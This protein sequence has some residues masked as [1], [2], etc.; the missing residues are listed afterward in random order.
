MNRRLFLLNGIAIVA[1]VC[2]HATHLGY[3]ALFANPNQPNLVGASWSLLITYYALFPVEKLAVFSVPAFL[4]TA[5]C[6]AAFATRSPPRIKAVAQQPGTPAAN[7]AN[8]VWKVA[9]T[10]IVNLV[11]P[12]V[13]WSI[14]IFILSA[15]DGEVL[16]PLQYAA[17]LIYG[18]AAGPFYFVPVMCQLYV[19]LPVLARWAKLH[20]RR[21]LLVAG[22]VQL[23]L[24]GVYYATILFSIQSLRGVMASD[25]HWS[26][27][28]GWVFFFM[29]GL[30]YGFHG[31]G[32][33]RW[34]VRYRWVWL[35]AVLVFGAA[36]IAEASAFGTAYGVNLR[37]SPLT[38]PSNLYALACIACF[39]AF[40][41]VTIP[42]SQLFY[43]L[44]SRTFGIYLMHGLVLT[45]VGRLVAKFVPGL[46]EV[47]W[48]YQPLLVA[49]GLGI[50]LL[51]MS[52]IARSP[53][54]KLHPYLFG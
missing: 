21:A 1:V 42:A 23:L 52:I 2:N 31:E 32:V 45:Y 7:P 27:M 11:I 24:L 39:L 15:W 47:E 38:L 26:L 41:R 14:V 5:G 43:A 3:V 51:I 12:H 22:L 4:F 35:G 30:V 16:T 29:F 33:K 49:V 50:P 25:R 46:M 17:R 6:F 9:R 19:L 37:F 48:L 8:L 13:I 10:R 18:G 44:S 28:L 36:A 34:L 54:R 20:P 53:A 40:E